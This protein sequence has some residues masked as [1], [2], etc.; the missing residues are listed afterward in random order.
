MHEVAQDYCRQAGTLI[1]NSP[2]VRDCRGDSVDALPARLCSNLGI[3]MD[4]I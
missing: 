2:V 1:R 3:I 4:I